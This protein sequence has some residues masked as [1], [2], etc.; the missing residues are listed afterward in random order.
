MFNAELKI[1]KALE[2]SN[3]VPHHITAVGGVLSTET[4]IVL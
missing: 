4:R 2:D 3:K 1:C